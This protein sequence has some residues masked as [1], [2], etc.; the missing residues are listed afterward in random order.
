M[1]RL[2]VLIPLLAL[3]LAACGPAKEPTYSVAKTKQCL[4]DKGAKIGGKL[5]FVASTATGGAFHVTLPANALTI[6][7]GNNTDDGEQIEKAYVRFH[8]ANVG[9]EDILKRQS[10]AVMLWRQHP[11]QTDLETV[12]SC[13]SS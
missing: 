13:L 7:F 5:D 8:A 6:A 9:I 11:E 2:I 4:S 12:E 1:R 10:N 3:T